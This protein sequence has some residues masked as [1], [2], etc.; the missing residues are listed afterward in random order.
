MSDGTEGIALS[1]LDVGSAR[2]KAASIKGTFEEQFDQPLGDIGRETDTSYLTRSVIFDPRK[3]KRYKWSNYWIVAL[4]LLQVAIAVLPVVAI[5]QTIYQGRKTMETQ[6]MLAST[7]DPIHVCITI[8]ITFCDPLRPGGPWLEVRDTRARQF[9]TSRLTNALLHPARAQIFSYFL[10][11]ITKNAEFV[12]IYYCA[13]LDHTNADPVEEKRRFD[14][15]EDKMYSAIWKIGIW[16][17]GFVFVIHLALKKRARLKQ[18]RK[19]GVRLLITHS[20]PMSFFS[21]ILTVL[22][23]TAE[24]IGCINRRKEFDVECWDIVNSNFAFAFVFVTFFFLANFALPFRD[25]GAG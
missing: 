17:C 5:V 15:A 12:R 16:T 9:K 2:L 13:S 20:L 4:L 6:A 14:D 23:I 8:V 10:L 18:M 22:Y 1:R 11:V 19:K 25:K 24:S 7:L 21:I 3:R